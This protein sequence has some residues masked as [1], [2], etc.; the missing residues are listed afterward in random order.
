[1]KVR[2]RIY[3]Y[4][5]IKNVISYSKIKVTNVIKHRKGITLYSKQLFWLKAVRTAEW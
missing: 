4:P 3:L 1:M 2:L 5:K